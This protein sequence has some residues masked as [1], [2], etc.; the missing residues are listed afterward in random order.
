[1]MA[2][3]KRGKPV[4]RFTAPEPLQPEADKFVARG[5]LARRTSGSPEVK[6]ARQQ[7]IY[8]DPH[9]KD[10]VHLHCV[11]TKQTIS[12]FAA[13]AFRLAMAQR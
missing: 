10:E 7:T 3:K 11:K 6:T 13:A 8:L 1:M 2:A 12:E 5:R 9:L 4:L